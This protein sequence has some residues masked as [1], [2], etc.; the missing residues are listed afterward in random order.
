M[1]FD[2]ATALTE[3]IDLR[4]QEVGIY[5]INID[6]YERSLEVIDKEYAGDDDVSV[7]M[8]GEHRARL[9][10]VLVTERRE[11]EK[12]KLSLRIAEAQL[13]ALG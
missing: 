7:A 1:P 10:A 13:A 5:E 12:A 6:A 3:N 8:R 11:C 4:K 9:E 2:R